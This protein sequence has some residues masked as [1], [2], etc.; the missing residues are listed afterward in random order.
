MSAE[1]L[2][3]WSAL[4]LYAI[5]GS[6]A[7][8]GVARARFAEAWVMG[9]LALGLA[10]HAAAIG[11]R[12]ERLGHGPFLTMYEILS[13]NVWSLLAIY[14]LACWRLPVLR[15]S[16]AIVLPVLFVM[17]LW[18]ATQDP[19]E[20]HLPPTYRTL[21][22][23]VHVG[24]GKAFLGAVL[25]AVGLAGMVLA[26]LTRRGA[27]WFAALPSDQ[28]LDE[29]AYRFLAVALVCETL[30]L[31]A[32]A[33]WAQDAWGRYWAWDPLE[34]W[35]FLTWLLLAGALHARSSFRPAP[36]AGAALAIAVFV[37][38]FLTFFGV[39]FVTTAPHQGAI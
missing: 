21:L 18:L 13:S 12:W 30:M 23:Y 3:L 8:A 26:R 20:G 2:A 39:P 29:L 4:S 14:L 36:P 24:F 32:G 7:L 33:V 34:T 28:Q 15:P 5:A 25:V 31:I 37:L 27:A 10:L 35:A 6:L 1:M 19:R 9:L 11:V 16:A 22:L 38:A 17:M